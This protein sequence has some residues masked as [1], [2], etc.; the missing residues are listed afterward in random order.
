M[1]T[2]SFSQLAPRV[3][4]H[5]AA[6]AQI[7]LE[8]EPEASTLALQTSPGSMLATDYSFPLRFLISTMIAS[9]SGLSWRP[10]RS[11]S[12][13]IRSTSDQPAATD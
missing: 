3:L 5:L 4:A 8:S 11:G 12:L 7:Q 6:L 1:G 13:S 2:L 10:T 9:N